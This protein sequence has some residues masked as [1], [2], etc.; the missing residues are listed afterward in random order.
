MNDN[1]TQKPPIAV[2]IDADNVSASSVD[3]IFK[4]VAKVGEPICPTRVW[5]GQLLF[6]N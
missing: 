1:E 6:G 4:I 3:S 2:L 5:H